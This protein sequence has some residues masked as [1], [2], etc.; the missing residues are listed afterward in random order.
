[1]DFPSNFE[2]QT[3]RAAFIRIAATLTPGG[4][5]QITLCIPIE[6]YDVQGNLAYGGITRFSIVVCAQP[7]VLPLALVSS[8]IQDAGQSWHTDVKFFLT[9]QHRIL[10]ICLSII[11]YCPESLVEQE[12][13]TRDAAFAATRLR[14]AERIPKPGR[15]SRF[16]SRP[17][18]TTHGD[19]ARTSSRARSS[20]IID[21]ETG[22]CGIR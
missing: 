13:C 15:R 7:H 14:E 18:N 2:N 8:P 21:S 5:T 11:N 6:A 16:N 22:D 12:A 10:T 9:G 17:N 1:M 3:F 20:R 19:S 4:K